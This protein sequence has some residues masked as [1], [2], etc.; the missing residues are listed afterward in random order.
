MLTIDKQIVP[1]RETRGRPHSEEH[2]ALVKLQVG[3]SFVSSKRRETLYQIARA[4]GVKVSIMKNTEGEGW[5]VWKKSH[6]TGPRVRR[7]HRS[8]AK[9]PS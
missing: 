6:P 5:R 2:K 3:E 9:Q 1:F 7:G 4:I 8:L